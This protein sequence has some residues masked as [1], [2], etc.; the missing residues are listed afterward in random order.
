MMLTFVTAWI[1]AHPPSAPTAPRTDAGI[2]GTA[3]FLAPLI[4]GITNWLFLTL[5]IYTF[6]PGSGGHLNPTITLGTF[7]ARLISFPRLVLYLTGQAAGG[8]LG[9][10]IL[11]AA[12]GS[13]DLAVGGCSV[14]TTLVPVKDAFLLEFV[15]CLCLVFLSFGVALDPRQ[16]GIFGP[17]LS[18]WLVGLVLGLLSWGSAFTRAGYD[19]AGNELS[20]PTR[21]YRYTK[22]R[23]RLESRPLLWG[24]RG[25][26]VPRLSLDS[27]GTSRR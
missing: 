12:Y 27:L 17:A 9:G 21:R 10:L 14:D 19:G 24:L 26:S 5:F 1:G 4:G 25:I 3:G 23:R 15:Y 13:R 18:P 16:G 11:A 7:F 2:Y 22:M 6:S 20:N 8:A